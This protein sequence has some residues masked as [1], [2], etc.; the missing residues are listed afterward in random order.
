M[1]LTKR[2][3]EDYTEDPVK[4]S[5]LRQASKEQGCQG[6]MS[7]SSKAWEDFNVHNA[8][9]KALKTA[10]MNKYEDDDEDDD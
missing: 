2:D 1:I 9:N 5:A 4:I 6:A 10:F 8:F 7:T 3:L